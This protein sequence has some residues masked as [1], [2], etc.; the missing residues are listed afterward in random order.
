MT[1]EMIYCRK[2][3][4]PVTLHREHTN[5]GWVGNITILFYV[6]YDEASR[7]NHIITLQIGLKVTPNII[8][9]MIVPI[10]IQINP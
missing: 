1:T 8:I 10:T 4:S 6:R 2:V 5:L 9:I 3:F 7:L